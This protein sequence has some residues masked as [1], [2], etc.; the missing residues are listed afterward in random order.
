MGLLF[1]VVA[2]IPSFCGT[3]GWGR[4]F[5]VWLESRV[6]AERVNGA[7]VS[8][9]GWNPEFMRNG[10]MGPLFPVVAGIPRLCGTG[11][12]GRCF[13]VWLESRVYAERVDGA[14]VSRCGWNPEIMRNGWMGPLFAVVAGI[15]SFCGTGGWGRCFPLWLESRVYAER[16]DGAVVSRCGELEPASRFSCQFCEVG[17]ELLIHILG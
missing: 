5:P 9:C 17:S 1:P 14:V 11:G 6:S 16:V 2:G 13:P 3:G 4:C 7:V 15:P 12:W 10:W 8:R